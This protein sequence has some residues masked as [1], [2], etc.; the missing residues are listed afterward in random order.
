[1][2]TLYVSYIIHFVF[3]SCALPTYLYIYIKLVSCC[4]P[5][6]GG[7]HLGELEHKR[8]GEKWERLVAGTVGG[9]RT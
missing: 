6:D 7:N 9:E 2:P 3:D 1:M 8:T 5:T 4:S